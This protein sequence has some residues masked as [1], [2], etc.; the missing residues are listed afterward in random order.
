[1][2]PRKLRWILLCCLGLLLAGPLAAAPDATLHDD[3][4]HPAA[5]PHWLRTEL[6]FGM[7]PA[8]RPRQL[9]STAQWRKFLDEEVSP[10]FPDGLS[11]LEV[12]G[13]W[14]GKD[15][16]EIQRLPSKLLVLLHPD[17]PDSAAKIEAIRQAWKQRT[18]DQSVLRVTQAVEVSF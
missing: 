2:M 9:V 5:A 6:Y 1:M 8:D 18:G 16:R 4:A 14:R 17:T 7:R 13:Q 15:Q 12:Y 3:P 11:V 10:R